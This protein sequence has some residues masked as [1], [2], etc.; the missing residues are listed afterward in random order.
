MTS[1]V[2]AVGEATATILWG[3]NNIYTVR[4]ED[5]REICRHIRIKGKILGDATAREY[6]PLAPGD[7][8]TM[9]NSGTAWV[10]LERCERW[11]TV[12]RWN[13]KRRSPQVVAANADLLVVVTSSRDPRYRSTFVDRVL[14]M[15]ELEG[16]PAA[17]VV[18]KR[19]L[20]PHREDLRHQAILADLGY[21]VISVAACHG[22]Q[23]LEQLRQWCT[24]KVA[25]LFGQSGVGKSTIINTLIPQAR[26]A[27]G[28]ISRK[29]SRGRHTTTLAQQLISS[30]SD[31]EMIIVD[32]PGVREFDLMSYTVQEIAAGFREFVPSI[33]RCRMPGC[34]HR[35]EPGCQVIAAVE[36]QEISSE[37]YQSY[38]RI[39]EERESLRGSP[40]GHL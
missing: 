22:A 38:R 12:V 36:R 10:I 3:A 28:E 11:N 24:G 33:P 19:D 5:T 13:R 35:H 30:T 32:T 37:R 16:I 9:E 31:G 40:K 1:G 6:A 21:P 27:V 4:R 23:E 7:R 25:V 8:V 26:L 34:T 20:R 2:A 39:G 17:V 29:Y 14:A 18:N 15:A